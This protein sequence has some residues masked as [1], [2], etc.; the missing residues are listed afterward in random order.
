MGVTAPSIYAAFGDKKRL[1]IEA[2]HRYVSGPVTS[3]SIID[4]AA[5]ALDAARGLLQASAAGFTG[6]DTPPGCLLASSAIS[7]SAEA[8]D[9]Q[10]QLAAIRLAIEARLAQKIMHGIETG[11]VPGDTDAD[12]LAGHVMAVIQGMSTLA[13]DGASRDKLMR[14]AI[15]ALTGWPGRSSCP[16]GRAPIIV[17]PAR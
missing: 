14:V 16:I 12:A 2:V 1:F 13:R 11:E 6:S 4:Q 9:V 17:D 5:T 15:A 3:Q 7:C 8:A 10:S